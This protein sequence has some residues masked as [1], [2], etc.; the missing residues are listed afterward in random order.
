MKLY[1]ITNNTASAVAISDIPE[2]DYMELYRDLEVRMASESYHVAHYFAT[3][4]EHGLKFYLILLNDADAE[5]L[6]T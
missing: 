2:V 3:E 4:I 1:H 6:I 5:V